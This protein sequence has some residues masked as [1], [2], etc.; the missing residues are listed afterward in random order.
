MADS[1]LCYTAEGGN[2]IDG[3]CLNDSNCAPPLV[4]GNTDVNPGTGQNYRCGPAT[5]STVV[6][7]T[8]ATT[9]TAGCEVADGGNPCL[10]CCT[11]P[12]TGSGCGDC[13]TGC[14]SMHFHPSNA[15]PFHC[16]YHY[17]TKPVFFC[18]YFHSS[19]LLSTYW[20]WQSVL[21]YLEVLVRIDFIYLIQ[22]IACIIEATTGKA[23]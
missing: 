3:C 21:L 2:P 4:C 12:C 8:A 9:T 1:C 13:A 23:G 11:T 14:K 7:S 10:G 15:S 19:F 22:G 6:T 5:T 20:R 17:Q 16:Y 18:L